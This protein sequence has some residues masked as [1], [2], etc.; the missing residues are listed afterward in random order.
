MHVIIVVRLPLSPWP[1][2]VAAV[3]TKGSRSFCWQGHI[4]TSSDVAV[5]QCNTQMT[6]GKQGELHGQCF[7]GA[8]YY[9]SQLDW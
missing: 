2:P 9:Y 5:E 6:Q 4:P 1:A 7:C 8:W 3:G